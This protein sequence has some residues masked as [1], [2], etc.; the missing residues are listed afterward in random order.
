V[1]LG[2]VFSE[3]ATL[4]KKIFL[5]ETHSD[6]IIDGFRLKCKENNL[7]QTNSQIIYF[8][9]SAKGNNLYPIPIL[10]DGSLPESQ[11]KGYRDFFMNHEMR[12]LGY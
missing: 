6:F 10:P 11:P 12:I 5:I 9:R 8:E 3:L 7:K 4:E 1:A 2:T